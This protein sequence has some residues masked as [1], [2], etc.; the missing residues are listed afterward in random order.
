MLLTK[1]KDSV[2]AFTDA[3]NSAMFTLPARD[4]L[5]SLT[6]D[7]RLL[8]IKGTGVKKLELV[9]SPVLLPNHMAH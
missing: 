5:L 2:I 8:I 9:E 7:F 6:S 3:F 4:I 1:R